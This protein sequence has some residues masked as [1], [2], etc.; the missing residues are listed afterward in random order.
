[1]LISSQ[2]I[3]GVQIFQGATQSVPRGDAGQDRD[4][5]A[6]LSHT[7]AMGIL[8][9][10]PGGQAIFS[11]KRRDVIRRERMD[12]MTRLIIVTTVALL[13]FGAGWHEYDRDTRI[14]S[15]AWSGRSVRGG[16][17]RTTGSSAAGGAVV[18]GGGSFGCRRQAPLG[19]GI[20]RGRFRFAPGRF[21]LVLCGALCGLSRA[22]FALPDFVGAG[23]LCAPDPGC[24]HALWHE[25]DRGGEVHSR[26]EHPGP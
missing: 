17:Y 15:P 18:G 26:L 7:S 23:F 6:Q 8:K 9:S 5:V 11:P 4:L 2:L 24:F 25:G 19:R 3:P 16:L 21:D 12:I 14:F 20:G 13:L 1:M 22:D 10:G